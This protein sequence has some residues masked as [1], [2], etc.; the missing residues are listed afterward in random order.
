MPDQQATRAPETLDLP[1][2]LLAWLG[3]DAEV[4]HFVWQLADG[5]VEFTAGR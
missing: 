1:A 2:D 3:D 4:D 5:D